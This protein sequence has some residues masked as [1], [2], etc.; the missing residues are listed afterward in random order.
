[1][2]HAIPY[3][4]AELVAFALLAV[5]FVVFWAAGSRLGEGDYVAPARWE[6]R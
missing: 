2:R 1:M 5:V 4:I 6:E 3:A